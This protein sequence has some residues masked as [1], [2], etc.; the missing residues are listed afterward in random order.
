MKNNYTVFG[1]PI[2]LT[3]LE[4]KIVEWIKAQ[5]ADGI[6]QIFGEDIE[7]G[8]GIDNK[9]ARGALSSLV[10]KGAIDVNTEDGGLIS[11]FVD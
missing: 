11:L 6:D 1:K 4:V 9:V 2:E 3:D 10:K 8:T 7:Y 5:L